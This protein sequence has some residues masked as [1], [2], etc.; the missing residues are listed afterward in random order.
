MDLF[1]SSPAIPLSPSTLVAQTISQCPA[2]GV[3]SIGFDLSNKTF[4]GPS[5]QVG[6]L[7]TA[8]LAWTQTLILLPSQMEASEVQMGALEP[9]ALGGSL[10]FQ[11]VP[12]WV[13]LL[14][15]RSLRLLLC[16]VGHRR[17]PRESWL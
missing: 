7:G 15:S 17:V 6:E 5:I 1:S 13:G 2:K 11:A 8:G 9:V 4:A 3:I 14:T 12:T 10:D 16:Q